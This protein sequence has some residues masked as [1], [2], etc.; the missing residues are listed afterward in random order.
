M[1]APARKGTN[2]AGWEGAT[3]MRN[4]LSGTPTCL[5]GVHMNLPPN[6]RPGKFRL[7]INA[8]NY[9]PAHPT[10]EAILKHGARGGYRGSIPWPGRGRSQRTRDPIGRVTKRKATAFR[11]IPSGG[12]QAEIGASVI[13]RRW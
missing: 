9:P 10:G 5:R 1:L 11:R 12:A 8:S 4:L 7:H 2:F 13:F 6:S 3:R